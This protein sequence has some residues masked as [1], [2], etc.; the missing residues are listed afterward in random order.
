MLVLIWDPVILACD[1]CGIRHF[2]AYW[3][4]DFEMLY[5]AVQVERDGITQEEPWPEKLNSI[6][7][8]ESHPFVSS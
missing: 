7:S 6:V 3:P 8:F 4:I 1:F 2:L 5:G